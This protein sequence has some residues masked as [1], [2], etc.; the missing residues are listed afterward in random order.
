MAESLNIIRKVLVKSVVNEKL[1]TLLEKELVGN[2]DA[3]R[4]DLAG[5]QKYREDFIAQCR[6]KDIKPDY[7]ILKKMA[8]EEER[9]KNSQ[10]QLE[11]RIDE[12]DKLADGEEYTHGTVDSNMAV[13]VG[14]NWHSVMT[15][16]EVILADGIVQE[17]RQRD[18]QI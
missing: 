17:I 9:F 13:N 16:V 14:D 7:D 11:K 5:L 4:S 10:A 1:R 18:I 15:G 8:M 12:V 2:L 6:L 3:V